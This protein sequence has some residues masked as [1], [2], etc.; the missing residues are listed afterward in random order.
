M[1]HAVSHLGRSRQDRCSLLWLLP[2]V[3]LLGCG[4][5]SPPTVAVPTPLALTVPMPAPPKDP[6]L[7]GYLKLRDVKGLVETFGG[8]S[9]TAAAAAQGVNLGELQA[10]QPAAL[11]VWDPGAARAP[12]E[13][14]AV[15][16]LPVAAD[17]TL[18]GR[19]KGL[20]EAVQVERF[21]GGSLAVMNSDA[22]GRA[23]GQQAVL[24]ELL[25]APLQFDGLLYLNA[26]PIV[27]KYLPVLRQGIAQMEPMLTMA[28]S[29]RKDAPSPKATLGMLEAFA[30]SLEPLRAVALGAKP[31]DGGVE[32][33][34]MV[35]QRQAGPGG[36]LAAPDLAQF[37]PA[38][39][40]RLVWNSRDLRRFVDFYLRA[41]GPLL[42]E[43]PA[44]KAQLL[45][46]IDDWLKS[47]QRID[48]AT[49]ISLGGE[50]LLSL[51]GLV[52]VDSPA[53][54][55]KLA[56]RV[57]QLLSAGPIHDA[58]KGLGVDLQVV[59]SAKVRKLS[60]WPVDR[61]QYKVQLSAEQQNSPAAAIWQKLGGLSYEVVQV[62]PY[63]AYALNGSLD[64]VVASLFR[65]KG[66]SPLRALTAFP[67]GGHLYLDCNVASL[68]AGIKSL[69]PP[70]LGE[71]FPT[72]AAQPD[73]LMLFGYD[74]GQTGYYKLRLP[75]LLLTALREAAR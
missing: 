64:E 34:A 31:Y 1:S 46:L 60:G 43:K 42:D 45:P 67:P 14:P 2:S 35:E 20:G 41:Y 21:A 54:L 9:L 50:R 3:W 26:A 15:A 47:S 62:G 18:A 6:T 63:V 69:L 7:F 28:A 56:D 17:G 66:P 37:L 19:L 5:K 13:L 65:G 59:H 40:L 23:H 49:A 51:H 58:Y 44:V 39:D 29:M 74:S 55:L 33:S 48:S 27:D 22:L 70:P 12:Q 8:P 68:M 52:R 57:A 36:P 53:A 10:G 4:P 75:I 30:A 73:P 61:F 24:A 32:L 71:R 16:L 11:F 38:A 25:Q 72:L